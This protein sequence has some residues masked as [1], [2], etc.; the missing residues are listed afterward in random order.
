MRRWNQFSFLT[1]WTDK[2]VL[3]HLA[4]TFLLSQTWAWNGIPHESMHLP[5]A[6]WWKLALRGEMEVYCCVESARRSIFFQ[7]S[8]EIHR[9]SAVWALHTTRL[10]SMGLDRGGLASAADGIRF[11]FAW[12]E[13][14]IHDPQW[15]EIQCQITQPTLS[16]LFQTLLP[17]PENT[18]T[19]T[20]ENWPSVVLVLQYSNHSAGRGATPFHCYTT[21]F[22]QSKMT[23]WKA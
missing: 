23:Q 15:A 13:A 9:G 1:F 18:E 17:S 7:P 8:R 10:L 2:A 19:V 5:P 16:P 14:S 21:C 4:S 20:V 3:P 22:S 11:C 6:C 12:Q